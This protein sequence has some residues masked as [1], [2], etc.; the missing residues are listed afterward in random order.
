MIGDPSASEFDERQ[1]RPDFIVHLQLG[2]NTTTRLLAFRDVGSAPSDSGL[3]A[4]G[5]QRPPTLDQG[6]DLGLG[7][8]LNA[9]AHSVGLNSVQASS[10]THED[11][12][13]KGSALAHALFH[14]DN[15]LSS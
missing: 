13:A 5:H 1:R 12:D 4:H 9:S 7:L 14:S 6:V 11:Y 3:L 15:F 8:Q 2:D 10:A